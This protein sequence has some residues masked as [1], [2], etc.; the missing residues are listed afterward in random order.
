MNTIPPKILFPRTRSLWFGL[1]LPYQALKLIFINKS[2]LFWSVLPLA[3]T[4]ILFIYG[5]SQLQDYA[6]SLLQEYIA[7]LGFDPAGFIGRFF[8]L[9][10]KIILWMVAALTFIFT[11]SIVASPFNDI[12]AERSERVTEIP[13]PPI[14]KKTLKAHVKLIGIEFQ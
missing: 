7:R 1:T 13:L 6:I 10:G 2:L 4:F 11:S 5:I 3:L 14:T 8:M 12:L 9:S